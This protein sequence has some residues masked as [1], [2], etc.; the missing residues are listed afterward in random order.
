MSASQSDDERSTSSVGLRAG[1]ENTHALFWR[2]GGATHDDAQE[3]Q[4][5]VCHVGKCEDVIQ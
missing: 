4:L 5:G 2:N 3:G 1:I